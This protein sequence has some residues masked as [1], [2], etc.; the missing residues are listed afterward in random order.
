[1][2][3][4]TFELVGT[5]L[6]DAIN[7]EWVWQMHLYAN[8]KRMP[9]PKISCKESFADNP[10]TTKFAKVFSCYKVDSTVFALCACSTH[11]LLYSCI[12]HWKH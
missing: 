11:T 2:H 7:Y 1:M 8:A 3:I 6:L 9:H 10:Q 12:P 4:I 5:G